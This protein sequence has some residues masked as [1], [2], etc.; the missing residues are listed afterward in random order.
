MSLNDMLSIFSA[1]REYAR[2][3][4]DLINHRTTWFVTIQ[5]V[6]LATFGFSIQKYYEIS[7]KIAESKSAGE[8]VQKIHSVSNDVYISSIL[9]ALVGIV[10]CLSAFLGILA[11]IAA[12]RNVEQLWRDNFAR[13]ATEL[14]LPFIAGGG[15]NFMVRLG[16]WW[17]LTLP[18]ML[19]LCWLG[20]VVFVLV[21]FTI[22]PGWG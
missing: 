16:D 22:G 11:S 7:E 10:S 12:Q 8:L 20:L 21:K 6:L 2:T 15:D 1:Y 14:S 17:A 9:L 18:V 19:F 13:R 4:N 3:E 5:S